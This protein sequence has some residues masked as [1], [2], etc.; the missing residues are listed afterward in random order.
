MPRGFLPTASSLADE[1]AE[2]SSVV[3]TTFASG[4]LPLALSFGFWKRSD[5]ALA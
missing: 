1:C 5:L 2:A 3:L 4:R